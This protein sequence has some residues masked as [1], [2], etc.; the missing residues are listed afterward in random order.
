MSILIKG[1]RVVNA[2]NE[3]VGDVLVEGERIAQVGPSLD[4]SADRVIDWS[5]ARR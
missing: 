5:A 1:G 4:V 2:D 3:R